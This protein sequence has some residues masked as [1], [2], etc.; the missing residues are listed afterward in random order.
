MAAIRSVL[1]RAASRAA[2]DLLPIPA[3]VPFPFLCNA[4][5]ALFD[6]PAELIPA[7]EP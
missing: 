1:A 7:R 3:T 2:A 5:S 6:R 4:G